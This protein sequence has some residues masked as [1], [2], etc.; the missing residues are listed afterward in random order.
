MSRRSVLS[1]IIPLAFILF[2]VNT[3]AIGYLGSITS[4]KYVT[5]AIVSVSVFLFF[6]VALNIALIVQGGAFH[7]L[8]KI[9]GKLANGDVDFKS[10]K[11]GKSEVGKAIAE[12]ESVRDRLSWFR[13]E[14]E[15]LR[16]RSSCADIDARANERGLPGIYYNIAERANAYIGSITAYLD[17][18]G[19]PAFSIDLDYN[20]VYINKDARELV[21]MTSDQ[22]IGKKCYDYF[23][24]NNC[25]TENC[26]CAAAIKQGGLVKGQAQS[27]YQGKEMTFLQTGVKIVDFEDNFRNTAGLEILSDMTEIY[28][29]KQDAENKANQTKKQIEYTGATIAE[30]TQKTGKN[31]ENAEKAKTLSE[32]AKEDALQGSGRMHEMLAAMEEIKNASAGIA[33]IIKAIEDIAFQTNILALNAAVEAA[34]A[35]AHGK[36]F[37]VVAEE[38]RNL[39]ARSAGSAKETTDLIANTVD[40]VQKGVQ[41]ANETASALDKIVRGISD[42][43]A[44]V[45]EIA[46]ASKEQKV[47]I[48]EIE[49]E[50]KQIE[51]VM[52]AG[53]SA[54]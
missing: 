33:N 7:E 41:I 15:R 40:K 28:N 42:A 38:V 51:N 49:D 11:K 24:C 43:E 50:I 21:N 18:L 35:G 12:L 22:L 30:M 14:F 3:I 47:V 44:I 9:C 4:E 52:T 10:E 19:T 53:T 27:Y 8:L 36:G 37:A 29:L 23:K 32:T 16:Y 5:A 20:L 54:Y 39:A 13:D 34:R 45:V 26:I 31:V 17:V 46:D 25:R 1:T 48:T 6:S 2:A